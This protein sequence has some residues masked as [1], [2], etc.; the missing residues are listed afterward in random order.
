MRFYTNF[1]HLFV[2][3]KGAH[4]FMKTIN[5]IERHLNVLNL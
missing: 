4:A 5:I 1:C 3:P 2:F